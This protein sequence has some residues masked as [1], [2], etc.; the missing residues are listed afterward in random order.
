MTSR[1]RV[2]AAINHQQ[3]D[4]VPLDMGTTFYTGISACALYRLRKY[5]GLK[6][7]PIDILKHP[8]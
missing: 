5:Y 8:R 2:L 7:R 1:E 3:P 4:R 6:T